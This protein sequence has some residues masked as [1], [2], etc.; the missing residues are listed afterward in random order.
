[1]GKNILQYL[2]S[3]YLKLLKKTVAIE[4][5]EIQFVTGNQVF[6]FW[7]EDSF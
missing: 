3:G 4:W 2:F 7:H 6:G 5:Q 1:M